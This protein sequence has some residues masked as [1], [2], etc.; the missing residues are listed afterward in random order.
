MSYTTFTNLKKVLPENT[1]VQLTDDEDIGT[2]D[3][4]RVD[5]AIAQADGVIDVYIGGR[6]SV[7]LATVPAVI[8][9]CSDYIAVY[10]LYKRRVE[11]IPETRRTS[12]KDAIRTLEQIRDGKM[13]LPVVA[14]A[15][16]NFAFGAVVSGHFED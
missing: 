6:Y 1:L 8:R 7:P 14:E 11:E 12:Y 13:P 10:V 4:G 3:S 2:V 16:S 15:T 9:Q 5:E